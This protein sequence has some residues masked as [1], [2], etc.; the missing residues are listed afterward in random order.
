MSR[1][2]LSLKSYIA[3]IVRAGKT[4]RTNALCIPREAW[5]M[6]CLKEMVMHKLILQYRKTQNSLHYLLVAAM[7]IIQIIPSPSPSP[8]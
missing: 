6:G 3:L 7:S 8:A 1:T 2:V 4:T 5:T